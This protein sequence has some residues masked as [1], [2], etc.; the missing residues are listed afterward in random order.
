MIETP[1]EVIR[2]AGDRVW[3]KLSERQG[4]C[5]RCD[6][7]GG[8]RS[9][10]ITDTFGKPNDVFALESSLSVKVGDRVKIAIVEGAPLRAALLSYGLAAVMMLAGAGIGT[11]FAPAASDLA[12]AVGMVS[13]LGVAYAVNRLLAR[14]RNW[15]KG[16]GM[17]LLPDTQSCAHAEHS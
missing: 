16:L 3:V 14:S 7:P 8:C 10:R 4:G 11:L 6:E 17:T 12:A 5:G 15:R 2:I 9:M 1:A 13:G